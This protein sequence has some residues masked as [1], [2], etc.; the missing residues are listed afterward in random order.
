MERD[1]ETGQIKDKGKRKALHDARTEAN[2]DLGEPWTV[3]Q[4]RG[5]MPHPRPP[6]PQPGQT[7]EQVWGRVGRPAPEVEDGAEDDDM[8]V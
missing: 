4:A 3:V 1:N 7:P 6:P 5:P 8:E 2:G